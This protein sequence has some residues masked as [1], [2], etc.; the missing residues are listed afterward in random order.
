M[1]EATCSVPTCARRTHAY[2]YCNAHYS[3]WKRYGDPLAGQ[4]FR[5]PKGAHWTARFERLA[6]R[7]P[8]GACWPWMGAVTPS[9]YGQFFKDGRLH[10]AHRV[11]IEVTTDEVV[12]A[13][14]DVDHVCH[15]RDLSCRSVG[16]AC[17]HRRCV[18][19]A[20]LEV[21]SHLENVRR[22]NARTAG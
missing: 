7:G 12:P 3:R 1:A 16:R 19:P 11:A 17:L 15:N 9:G 5:S 8:A 21:V 10:A 2:I 20:H 14:M 13:Y 18:N 22:A 4:P 6:P